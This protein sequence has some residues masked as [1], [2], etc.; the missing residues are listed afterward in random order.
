MLSNA[1]Y[2]NNPPGPFLLSILPLGSTD[3][4][5]FPEFHGPFDSTSGPTEKHTFGLLADK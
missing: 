1:Q 3:S 2:N 4:T 5:L